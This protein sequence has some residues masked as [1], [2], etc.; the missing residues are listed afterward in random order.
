MD[1]AL[2]EI[3]TIRARIA[4]LERLAESFSRD[5]EERPPAPTDMNTIIRSRRRPAVPATNDMNT[6]IRQAAGRHE[7]NTDDA[8]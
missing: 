5:G 2:Q 6:I 7:E 8:A 4:E 3:R 1:D